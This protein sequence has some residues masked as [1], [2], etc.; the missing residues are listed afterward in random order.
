M[1]HAAEAERIL[2]KLGGMWDGAGPTDA[3]I[4]AAMAQAHATLALREA[5]VAKA[6]PEMGPALLRLYRRHFQ[7]V[8]PQE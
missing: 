4:R 7:Q 6:L 8:S 5:L 3:P 2:R 1:D